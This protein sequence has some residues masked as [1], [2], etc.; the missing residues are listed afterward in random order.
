MTETKTRRW[1]WG[2]SR[3]LVLALLIISA[4]LAGRFAPI[5]PHFQVPAELLSSQPLFNIPLLNVPVYLSN[6]LTAILFVDLILFLI[7]LAV[8]LSIR[9]GNLVPRGI[10]GAIEGLL[11]AVYNLTQTN[12]GKWTKT[13]FPFFATI[14]LI[15]FIANTMELI[16][17]VDSIGLFDEHHIENPESCQFDRLTSVGGTEVVG[18]S[19]EN[20][21]AA[22][23]V[24]F[25]R[26][27]ST[28]LNFTI[29]LA[30]ISVVSTQIIGVRALGLN[31]FTKFFN[32]RT[33]FTKPF[34][35]AID[36]FVGIIE[37]LSEMIKILSFSFRLFG[38]VLVGTILLFV[39]GTLLPVFV[40]SGILIFNFLVGIIQAFVFGLLTMIFMS[41]ATVSH[42]PEEGGEH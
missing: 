24:P 25:V 21:C 6:T 39:F 13:I 11:E 17:G 37:L 38:N 31:Y 14:L 41:L 27:V 16:P 5:Q 23:V 12:A 35:G 36:F 15:V 33:L 9:S 1:R 8:F 29:A 34:L 4:V 20:E 40:P 2:F 3:W 32:T 18:V 42:H 26:V 19:G 10:S 28:D 30:V 22:G 7:G